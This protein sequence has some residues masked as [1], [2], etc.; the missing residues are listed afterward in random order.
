MQPLELS[1]IHTKV[2]AGGV[3]EKLID[4]LDTL[5]SC[6]CVYKHVMSFT[7]CGQL[8]T[9]TLFSQRMQSQDNRELVETNFS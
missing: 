1:F 7:L 9:P 8:H 5:V 4:T 2:K 6:T 3:R